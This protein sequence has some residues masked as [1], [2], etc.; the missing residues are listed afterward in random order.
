MTCERRRYPRKKEQCGQV[1]TCTY[2]YPE[3]IPM[4]TTLSRVSLF[5]LA[6]DVSSS[7]GTNLLE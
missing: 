7:L 6:A 4:T 1:A 5:L 3:D 2:L